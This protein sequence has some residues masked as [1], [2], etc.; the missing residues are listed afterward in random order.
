MPGELRRHKRFNHAG[1]VRVGWED[2]QGRA[3]FATAKCW[4]VSEWGIKLAVPE[5][6][7]TQSVVHLQSERLRLANSGVVRHCVRFGAVYL[8]GIEFSSRLRLDMDNLE[9]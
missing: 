9:S 2:Q 6:V 7:R 5:P 1:K 4:D 3:K 8:V